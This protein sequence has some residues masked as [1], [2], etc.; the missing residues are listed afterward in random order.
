M[1]PAVAIAENYTN[2]VSPMVEAVLFENGD[3]NAK[4]RSTITNA[5]NVQ[6]L[7]SATAT[8]KKYLY[9]LYTKETTPD[10][11][12]ILHRL[13]VQDLP[14][15]ET[16]IS[17]VADAGIDFSKFMDSPEARKFIHYYNEFFSY[18]NQVID[19]AIFSVQATF[20]MKNADKMIEYTAEEVK[21]LICDH[22]AV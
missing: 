12:E 21:L 4:L 9:D 2:H 22:E 8:V 6:L 19:Y 15:V 11:L 7:E 20:A 5:E 16:F 13:F 18:F 1:S 17:L 10:E 14:K 3:V